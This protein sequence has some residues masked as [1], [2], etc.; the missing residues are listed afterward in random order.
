MRSLGDLDVYPACVYCTDMI[1]QRRGLLKADGNSV[2][3]ITDEDEVITFASDI[4]ARH[5]SCLTLTAEVWWVDGIWMVADCLWWNATKV[6]E[7]PFPWRL[8]FAQKISDALVMP[9][10]K[11]CIIWSPKEAPKPPFILQDSQA[12][13]DAGRI[14]MLSNKASEAKEVVQ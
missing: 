14:V 4:T 5:P 9:L 11:W 7:L 13:Y 3:I 12:V 1:P 6:A 8:S 10:V 2:E